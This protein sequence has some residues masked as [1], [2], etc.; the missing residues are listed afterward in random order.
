[1]LRKC[2]VCSETYKYPENFDKR[3]VQCFYIVIYL[4]MKKY[5]IHGKRK[6]DPG[7]A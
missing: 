2:E 6:D 4:L 5:C 3:H 7:T 1:M